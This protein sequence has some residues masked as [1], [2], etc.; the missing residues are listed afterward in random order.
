MSM[1]FAGQV[2][3]VIG[4]SGGIGQAIALLAARRGADVALTYRNNRVAGEDLAAQIGAIGRR[5]LALPLDLTDAES[6]TRCLTAVSEQLGAIDA[7]ICAAG[8]DLP[9]PAIAAVTPKQWQDVVLADLAGVFHLVSASLPHL[10]ASAGALVA[11]SSAGVRRYP[12]GDILSVAPKAAVEALI[13][14]VA[15]EEGR[16]GVRA[17]AVAVGVIEAGQFLRL[18]ETEFSEK[19]EAAAKRNTALKRLG[20]ADELA[21]VV[22]FLASRRSAYVTGQVIS[23]DGGYSL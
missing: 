22:L 13:R 10:R 15:R 12:P 14:G 17:N 19:W 6:V 21:E 8:P 11:L 16:H 1:E 3:V 18:R 9:Q 20:S 2:V 5:A 23:A 4:G 7:I